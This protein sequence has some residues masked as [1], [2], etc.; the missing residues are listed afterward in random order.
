MS[1]VEEVESAESRMNAAKDELLKY[2]E[3]QSTIDPTTIGD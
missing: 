2:V 1:T 3:R